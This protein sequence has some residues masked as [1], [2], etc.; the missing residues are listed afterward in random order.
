MQEEVEEFTSKVP[1]FFL[2]HS[3]R[4]R[5]TGW[6]QVNYK[7]G[8]CVEDS[9]EK[10]QYD[11]FYIKNLSITLD[12]HIFLKTVKAV[13]FGRGARQN[14]FKPPFKIVLWYTVFN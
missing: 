3:I 12:F 6:A 14:R 10:L 13:L 1:F 4:P 5:I 8:V 9:I 2:R 7:H 11:L